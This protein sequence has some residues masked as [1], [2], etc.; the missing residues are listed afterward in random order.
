MNL[1]AAVDHIVT[2]SSVPPESERG[3][4]AEFLPPDDDPSLS[5][6]DAARDSNEKLWEDPRQERSLIGCRS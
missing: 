3:L 5:K 2:A 4:A 1:G 6:Y